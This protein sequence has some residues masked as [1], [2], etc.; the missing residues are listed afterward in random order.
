M[1]LVFEA[2]YEKKRSEGKSYSTT[3]GAAIQPLQQFH[4]ILLQ[5]TILL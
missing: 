5:I 1:R 3:M 4:I 2:F